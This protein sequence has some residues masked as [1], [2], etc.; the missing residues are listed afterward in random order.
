VDQAM[1]Y[2]K[3]KQRVADHEEVFIP[4]RLV[5]AIRRQREK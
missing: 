2:V 5:K 1:N 3:S 4:A